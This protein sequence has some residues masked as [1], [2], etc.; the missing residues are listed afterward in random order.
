D[1]EF[2]AIVDRDVVHN[3]QAVLAFR[4]FLAQYPTLEAAYMA[5]VA[6]AK[7]DFPPLFL[8]QMTQIILRNIMDGETDTLKI[9]AAEC[10]FRQQT[11]TL[12]DGRIMVADHATVQLQ[13]GMA[14]MLQEGP[15]PDEVSIDIL[16]TET[17]DEYWQRSDMFNT[18]VDLAFTQP[19]LDGFCRVMESWIA[20]F[21]GITTRIQPMREIEDESWSWHV[22]LD[23]VSNDLFNDLYAGA[24]VGEDRLR[25]ILCLFKLE[26]E[27]GLIPEMAGKPVYLGLAMDEA[28]SVRMKP[29][30]LLANLPLAKV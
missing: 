26:A 8:E 10:L 5:V 19:A 20:H 2:D 9:R 21:L 17:A 14:R 16:A 25:S 22:G 4:S 28:G 27:E 13:A 3:Y 30:N 29:Q 1:A 7:I 12:D 18:S 11:V 23:A 15:A 24:D 6:G